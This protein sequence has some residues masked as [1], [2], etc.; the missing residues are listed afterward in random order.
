MQLAKGMELYIFRENIVLAKAHVL[1]KV[2]TEKEEGS[3]ALV[4]Y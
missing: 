1:S 2:F 4:F 3:F